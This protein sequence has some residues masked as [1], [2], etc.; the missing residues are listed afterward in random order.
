V[1]SDELEIRPR[2]GAT[3]AC[4][5]VNNVPRFA[6][7]TKAVSSAFEQSI[8]RTALDAGQARWVRRTQEGRGDSAAKSG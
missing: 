2:K 8:G 7:P 3:M 1:G 6:H 4:E 5:H